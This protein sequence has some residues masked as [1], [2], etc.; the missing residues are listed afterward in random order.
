MLR[1]LRPVSPS[2]TRVWNRACSERGG[3][4]PRE[5]DIALASLLLAHGLVMNGGVLH[6]VGCLGDDQVSAA[7]RGYSYFGFTSVVAVL[8][9]A[10]IAVATGSES[11]ELEVR[12]DKTYAQVIDSDQ[13]LTTAFERHFAAN[14]SLYAPHDLGCS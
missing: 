10:R 3:P 14:P 12:L 8:E 5:G 2:A 9:Q 1:I 7:C 13:V 4:T 11:G 6:A